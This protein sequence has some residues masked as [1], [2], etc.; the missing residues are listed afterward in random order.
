M[1]ADA[2]V[3]LDDGD[4]HLVQDVGPCLA[5]AVV[6]LAPARH[7]TNLA[8]EVDVGG[9]QTDGD[10]VVLV[11]D[12]SVKMKKSYVEPI[13]LSQHISE[14]I[15]YCQ[16]RRDHTIITMMIRRLLRSLVDPYKESRV[17]RNLRVKPLLQS[18]IAL[19]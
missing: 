18:N 1:P 5:E 17:L 10:D 2:L 13:W 7:Q 9:R 3:V 6:C 8:S 14:E 4:Q 15:K 19:C 12:R 11:E 16:H